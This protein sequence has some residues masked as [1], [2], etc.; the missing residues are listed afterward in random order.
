M[1]LFEKFF[2]SSSKVKIKR[3]LNETDF[4][5]LHRQMEKAEKIINNYGKSITSNQ[6][7]IVFR[8]SSLLNTKKEIEIA[9]KTYVEG[10]IKYDC[11]N[12][13]LKIPLIDT[14]GSLALFVDNATSDHINLE[15]RRC[16]ENNYADKKICD[17]IIKTVIMYNGDKLSRMT[18]FE[19]YIDALKEK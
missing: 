2:N 3:Y 12:D 7:N 9:F 16:K 8:K 19:K 5:E 10:C 15:F 4:I 14:Y 13:S 17:E 1:I 6:G 18:Y 11:W